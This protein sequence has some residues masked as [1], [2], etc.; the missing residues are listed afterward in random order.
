MRYYPVRLFATLALLAVAV[1]VAGA[2][3]AEWSDDGQRV[4][5]TTEAAFADV[6]F[7]LENAIIGRGLVVS[8][9]AKVGEMLERTAADL[10]YAPSPYAAAEVV[11]FCSAP[12][13]RA[14]V[15]A[16]RAD[17]VHCP[18]RIAV[19]ALVDEP[20]TVYLAYPKPT[21]GGATPPREAV[22]ALLRELVEEVL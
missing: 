9:V 11:E 20:G 4:V 15:D 13:T 19:Y 10:G 5:V 12:L 16:D 6:R 3:H 8:D 1:A 21:A 2:A 7:D 17:L 14:M 18:Y 22:E